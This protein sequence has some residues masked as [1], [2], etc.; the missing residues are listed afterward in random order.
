[1]GIIELLK[2]AYIHYRTQSLK[3]MGIK[4]P[5]KIVVFE[6][7]DWGSIRMPSLA[8]RDRLMKNGVLLQSPQSYDLYDTL[9][10]E[11]DLIGLIETLNSVRDK[12]NNPAVITLDTIVANPDFDRILQSDFTEYYYEPFTDTLKRYPRHS[13][14]FKLWKEGIAQKVF[15]PQFHGR[16]HLNVQL[17]LKCLKYGDPSAHTA[18]KEG[19]FSMRCFINGRAQRVL[20]AYNAFSIDDYPFME[21]SI[22]DGLDLFERI[23]GFRSKSMIAPC[24][25]WDEP[26]ERAAY[27]SGVLFLQGT[28]FN[29]H[30][31]FYSESKSTKSPRIMGHY[32]HHGQL[33]L[34]RNCIFEPSQNPKYGKDRCLH[35]IEH[36]FKLNHPAVVSCHRLNFIGDLVP[37]NRD[38]NLREFK[39]MLNIIVKKWPDVEFM[40]S[41]QLGRLLLG[42]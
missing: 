18:F 40:S 20:E 9:A 7:D 21:S 31:H 8:T 34:V 16:E 41:D 14:S 36:Q 6:S 22:K 28:V 24:Y 23:F 32:N 38:R 1:M 30:S 3:N 39:D 19:V 11:E 12:N 17:W 2:S 5:R 15:Y 42:Q 35:D 33:Q 10:S 4:T 13:K 25:T 27:E 37:E 29:N 26:V